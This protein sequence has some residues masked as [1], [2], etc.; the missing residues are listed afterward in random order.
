M[1]LTIN[2]IKYEPKFG[3]GFI[4]RAIQ[5]EKPENNDVMQISTPRLLFHSCAYA[6]IRNGL[7][8]R[9]TLFDLY[10][11]VDNGEVTQET[12]KLFQIDLFKSL[13]VHMPTE[14]T[15]EA[16]DAIVKEMTKEDKKKVMKA[17]VKTG[18]K[19]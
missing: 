6:D 7:E 16:L 5:E 19:T 17:G 18:K 8:P 2:G 15:R 1:E 14:E 10:D 4:E 12:T 11:A 13:R 3:L 9:I